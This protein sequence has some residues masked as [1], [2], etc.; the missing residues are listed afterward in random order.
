MP[1][2]PLHT[3]QGNMQC[4]EVESVVVTLELITLSDSL[5]YIAGLCYQWLKSDMLS[6]D[7]LRSGELLL[8]KVHVYVYNIKHC[9]LY[10]IKLVCWLG[11]TN[12]CGCEI[13]EILE[14]GFY[15]RVYGNYIAKNHLD[16]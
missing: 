11:T 13:N 5:F 10:A 6:S 7:L 3:Y 1:H 14:E 2:S 9:T 4:T 8:L 12:T 16:V 15:T